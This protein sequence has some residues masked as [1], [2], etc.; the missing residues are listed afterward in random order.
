MS[1]PFFFISL[2]VFILFFQPVAVFPELAI[3]SPVRNITIISLVSYFL[4]QDK[5]ELRF[6]DIKTNRYLLLFVFV[7][8]LSPMVSWAG[9]IRYNLVYWLLYIIVFYLIVKQCISIERVRKISLMIVLAVGYLSFYSL[10]MFVV[11]YQPGW[12]AGG[13]G[14][15]DNSNDLSLILICTIP[16]AMFLAETRSNLFSRFLFFG[17]AGMFAFNIL[18]TGSRTGILGVALVGILCLFFSRV[19]STFVKCV[20]SILL[21]SGIMV[22]GLS[23]VMSRG[24]LKGFHG[25]DSSDNRLVQWEAGLN[26]VQSNPFLGVGPGEFA[27]VA[28]EYDGIQ[29]LA[30]HNT[31]VQVFA[32]TG[33]PGGIFFFMFACHPLYLAWRFV[34]PTWRQKATDSLLAYQYLFVALSGFW[35]CAFFS[36]RYKSYILFILVAMIV[37]VRELLLK[38]KNE[39]A[40]RTADTMTMACD[41][42]E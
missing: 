29:G 31:L 3:L 22:I 4:L 10:S 38:G 33:I 11:D 37:A 30:P 23:V 39:V 42:N 27:S 14:W 19:M 41:K 24:D 20:V 16:L 13:Y 1:M 40:D 8:L 36:N 18:F 9:S 21:I 5:S 2:T 25:D 26:M 12:R 34:K 15:Y 7:Q 35:L 17:L 32:E 6:C 28:G